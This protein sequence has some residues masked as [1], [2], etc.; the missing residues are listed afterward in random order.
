MKTINL[1]LVNVWKFPMQTP[2]FGLTSLAA[3]VR[4]KLPNVNI[5]IIEGLNPYQ[6]ILT[7]KSDI[8]GFT[9][10]TLVYNQTIKLALKLRK[11]ITSPFIIGGVHLTALP[12]SL[13]SVFKLAVIGE[14][15]LTLV[16]ILK[17]FFKDPTLSNINLKNIN[18]IA[19]Y[20]HHKL[21]FTPPRKLIQNIDSLPFPAR[22]LTPMKK[23]YL[24]NQLNLFGIK[25]LATIMT[26]RG[27]PYKCIFCGSPVQWKTIRFHS[28]ERIVKEIKLLI[29]TYNIDGIMFWDDFFIA[30]QDRLKKLV[31]LIRQEKLHKK[32]TFLGYARANL[33]NLSTIKLL[34]SMNVKRLIYGLESGSERILKILKQHT[35]TMADNRRSIKLTRQYGIATSSGYI[36]GTP[37]ETL[38]DLKKTYLFMKKH[39]LDNTQIYILTPY[40]GT[41][42]WQQALKQNLV[43]ANM[44]FNKLFVQ[45]SPLSAKDFVKKSKPEIIKGRIFLNTKYKNNQEYLRLIFKMQK[46]AFWQNLQFY[47]KTAI[48]EPGL[49][50]KL[51]VKRINPQ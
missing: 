9:S 32:I 19:F 11:K 40:P 36:T 3:Y 43:S 17:K 33:I 48:K 39:P 1:T 14:G 30:P 24:K 5:K 12:E 20:H 26:S 29:K 42:I 25:K 35:V 47:I 37:G 49:P 23:Y 28:P 44:D 18:G 50:I 46:L 4:Q 13:H 2:H 22:N 38:A 45:L 34:K 8:I 7:T 31:H 21:Q 41:Q 15:E 6:K 10:D 51:M 27:C 16:E